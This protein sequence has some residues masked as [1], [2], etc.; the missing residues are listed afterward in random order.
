MEQ[1][2]SGKRINSA[3]RRCGRLRIATRMESQVRGLNQAMRNAAD[4]QSLCQTQL[5][6]RWTKFQH[7]AADA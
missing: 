2:S 4:G 7:A 3:G 6:E 5:K 1:L